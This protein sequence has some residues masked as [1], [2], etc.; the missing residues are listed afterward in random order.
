MAYTTI[1]DGRDHFRTVTYTGTGSSQSIT[2]VGFQPDWVWVKQRN[3]ARNHS[4]FDSV[5]G[6]QKE[7]NSNDSA[8]ESSAT[9]F[10]TAFGAD[11]F[12]YGSSDN[13][14]KS[15]GTYVSWNWKAGGSSVSNSDGS[16][17]TTVSA[18]TTA[19]FSIIKY[20]GNSTNST[21]GHGL[22]V[23]P[24]VIIFKEIDGTESWR[25]HHTSTP[26]NTTNTLALNLNSG[27]FSQSNWI[28]AISSSTISIGTDSSFNTSGNNYIAYCFAEKKGYSK[29]G[30]Y[31]GASSTNGTYIHLGFEPA[32][33]L[34][35]AVGRT[36]NWYLFDNKRLGYNVD[37]NQIYPD[38]T[39]GED[40]TDWIDFLSNGVK[41]RY[42]SIGLNGTGENYVY[43]AFAKNPFVSSA[44]VPGTAR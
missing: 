17:T 41:Y 42:N 6:V 23:A 43:L 38:V 27:A 36:E 2:G 28:S 10:L 33:F 26:N 13:G 25:V 39:N 12:T 9:S 11:G 32:F 40:T 37:Q 18:N 22:G 31:Q 14:N 20:A 35:K 30:I 21:I 34:A 29:F 7:L 19:G 24:S 1:N 5:R 3:E 4:L 44:G 8:V 16:I 15:G